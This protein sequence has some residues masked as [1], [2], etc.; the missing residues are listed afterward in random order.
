MFCIRIWPSTILLHAKG[1]DFIPANPRQL[2][3]VQSSISTNF[4]CS[5]LCHQN[6]QCR[7][8]VFDPPTCR[9]Y[10]GA[11]STGQVLSSPSSS[12]AVG[13]ILYDNVDSSASY[14]QSCDHCYPDRYLVCR[15]NQCL[16]PPNTYW[17]G[18]GQCVNQQF[19]DPSSTCVSNDWC[20]ADMNLTCICNQCQCPPRTFWYNQMCVPQYGAGAACNS[21]NQ[22]RNDLY[23]VCSRINK[24]CISK[25]ALLFD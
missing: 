12:M 17:N 23:M 4:G 18:H 21:S 7:T 11:Q 15:N 10:D 5:L 1:T 25:R 19:V 24:T 9:L 22:C 3:G 16:C 13:E 14:N 8:F 6:P 20:R 2:L